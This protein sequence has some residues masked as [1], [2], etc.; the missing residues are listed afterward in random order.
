MIVKA[1]AK[2]N[3]ALNIVSKLP[4][5]YH[6][7]DMVMLPIDIYDTI[8]IEE[9]D[10]DEIEG[11]DDLDMESNLMYKALN[12]IRE[13]YN[14]DKKIKIRIEKQ[15]PQQAGL[16]GGSSDAAFVLKALNQMWNLGITDEKLVEIGLKLGA[17]VPFFIINKPARVKGIGE[18]ISPFSI[19]KPLYGVVV[20]PCFGFKTSHMFAQVS[21]YDDK[22]FEIEKLIT[23]LISGLKIENMDKSALF[24]DF[25]EVCDDRIQ[26][27]K[28]NM[29]VNGASLT[30]M[31]GSGSSVVGLV[32][33][34]EKAE[35]LKRRLEKQYN[36]VEKFKVIE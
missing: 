36:F 17:D 7:L 33:S 20:K 27:I 30:V 22:S 35:K 9:T 4:N 12:I 10:K 13:E 29:I 3:I 8:K 14:I 15:I 11:F 1:N 23:A 24:N 34:S 25:E 21:S 19:A 16:G 31:S 26:N 32:D 5:G 2:I 18:N 28:S 6:E